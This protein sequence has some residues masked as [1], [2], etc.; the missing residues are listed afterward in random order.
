MYLTLIFVFNSMRMSEPNS[1]WRI[2]LYISIKNHP[3]KWIFA[4]ITNGL[5]LPF[6]RGM[7]NLFQKY[8]KVNVEK[9]KYSGIFLITSLHPQ[10]VSVSSLNR[11]KTTPYHD[12]NWIAEKIINSVIFNKI[13]EMSPQ[14]KNNSK[15]DFLCI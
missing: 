3:N 9:Q 13:N 6:S 10:I 4:T 11:G 2:L 8:M 15:K 7:D 1:F 5:L 12:Y 14:L